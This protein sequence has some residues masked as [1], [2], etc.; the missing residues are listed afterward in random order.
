MITTQIADALRRGG[1]RVTESGMSVAVGDGEQ[2]IYINFL[3]A[4]NMDTYSDFI[5]RAIL[6]AEREFKD[7]ILGR[8]LSHQHTINPS[9]GG[10]ERYRCDCSD[11]ECERR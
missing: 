8:K 7:A 6:N 11:P 2:R 10:D 3:L 1:V 5:G 9:S 4:G